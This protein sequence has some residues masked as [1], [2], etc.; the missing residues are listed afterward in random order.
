[1]SRLGSLCGMA[2]PVT[3]EQ[4]AAAAIADTDDLATLPA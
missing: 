3:S 4:R 2:D 1:V